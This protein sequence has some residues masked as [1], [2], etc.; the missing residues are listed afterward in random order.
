L[1]ESSAPNTACEKDS[2]KES[3]NQFKKGV[4]NEKVKAIAQGIAK[5]CTKAAKKNGSEVFQSDKAH[6]PYAGPAKKTQ[7]ETVSKGKNHQ[8]R[9][10]E[11]RWNYEKKDIPFFTSQGCPS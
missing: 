1:K 5:L 9:I 3:N 11:D 4:E 2:D 7:T 8:K 10:E 6:L